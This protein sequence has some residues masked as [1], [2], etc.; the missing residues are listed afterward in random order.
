MALSNIER[1]TIITFNDE[2]ATANVFTYNKTWQQH[3]EQQLRIRPDE[4]NRHGGR[5]YTLPKG[6]SKM[7]RGPRVLSEATRL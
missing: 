7:P 4:K 3:I 5:S 2:E 1:E 6:F